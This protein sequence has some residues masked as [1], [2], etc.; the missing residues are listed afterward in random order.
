MTLLIGWAIS[1]V[2]VLY[3]FKALLI[4][5]LLI[6]NIMIWHGIIITHSGQS[7]MLENQLA[8]FS[9]LLGG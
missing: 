1:E 9:T 4:Q 6:V 2:R 8:P 5:L 3:F 7:M